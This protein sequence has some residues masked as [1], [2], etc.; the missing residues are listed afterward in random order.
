MVDKAPDD[1]PANLLR[2]WKVAL[3]DRVDKAIDIPAFT[4]KSKLFEYVRSLLRQNKFI[5]T[6][7]GPLSEVAQARPFSSLQNVWEAKK[8][9]VII[10]NNSLVVAAF[11]RYNKL[12]TESELR[13]FERFEAHAIAFAANAEDRQDSAP[14]FPVEFGD[15]IAHMGG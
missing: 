12:L 4:S 5:H 6:H 14:M 3:E 2:E 7:F 11:R 13:A 8:T 10:P 9:E 15:M 1:F